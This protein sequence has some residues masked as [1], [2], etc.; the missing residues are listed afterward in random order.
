MTAP[1]PLIK[2]VRSLG[3]P[4]PHAV[5]GFGKSPYWG[6]RVSGK[7]AVQAWRK[8]SGAASETGYWP[9]IIGN[10]YGPEAGGSDATIESLV[11]TAQAAHETADEP[12]GFADVK[13]TTAAILDAAKE[14]PLEAWVARQRDPSHQ[15]EESL[16]KARFF[17]QFPGA[18]TLAETY[19]RAAEE[20]RNRSPLPL[21]DPSEYKPPKV[22]KNPPQHELHCLTY[23]D[24]ES[25]R[26]V[27]AET[28]TLLCVPTS[29]SW[30]VPA[31]LFYET[32]EQER[33]PQVHVAAL[34]WLHDRFGAELIGIEDRTLEV[35]P[36]VRPQ[37]WAD[38]VRAA[39]LLTAYSSCPV[40]SENELATTSELAVYLTESE[41]WTFCWP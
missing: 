34:R 6:L 25:R 24:S 41:Y 19:R 28:L 39:D 8:L 14:W 20:W 23:F 26:S 36:R 12:H 15:A 16:R 9:V 13:S 40:T 38:A 17:D 30:E 35:L 22:N 2:L 11:E 7:D 27:V 10:F 21:L 3:L 32:R 4:K 5:K 18:S 33:L 29:N 31:Y 37:T 1:A